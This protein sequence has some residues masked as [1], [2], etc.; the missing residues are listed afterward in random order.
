V[1]R[2]ISVRCKNR[3]V[4]LHAH[5]WL[6]LNTINNHKLFVMDNMIP[7]GTT[8][9][10]A[11]GRFNVIKGDTEV[12]RAEL[13]AAINNRGDQAVDTFGNIGYVN[14]VTRLSDLM[15]TEEDKTEAIKLQNSLLKVMT[16]RNV[17]PIALEDIR[18]TISRYG[19]VGKQKEKKATN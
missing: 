9:V 17:V 10:S 4:A 16:K 15:I 14:L 13:L 2:E 11:G 5:R 12:S 6:G 18:Q 7:L 3:R 8:A 1:L 19:K